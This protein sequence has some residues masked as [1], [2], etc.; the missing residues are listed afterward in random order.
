MNYA[1]EFLANEADQPPPSSG[2]PILAWGVIGLVVAVTVLAS[3]KEVP[4]G[5]EDRVGKTLLEI[6]ARYMIGAVEILGQGRDQFY[7]QAKVL[8]RG[9]VDHHLAFVVLAG[10]LAGP[11]EALRQLQI[12]ENNLVQYQVTGTKVQ[13][14]L[15]HILKRLYQDYARFHF[16]RLWLSKGDAAFLR[17][18]LGWFG[19]LAL[20]PA[21]I[22]LNDKIVNAVGGAGLAA[23]V[24]KARQDL[25]LEARKEVIAPAVQTVGAILGTICLLAMVALGGLVG[26]I[27]LLVQAHKGQVQSGLVVA[28]TLRVPSLATA[29]GV[30]SPATAH[31]VCLL[32][33]GGIY[34][35]TFALWLLVW[36]GLSWA[37]LTLGAGEPDLLLVGVAFLL[38]LAAL[39][40]PVLRGIPWSQVRQ[41]IGLTRGR[42]PDLEPLIGI[43]CYAMAL[44][45]LAMGLLLTV[46]LLSLG[47][48]QPEDTGNPFAPSSTPRHPLVD[49]LVHGDTQGIFLAVILACVVAP[50][51]EEIMFRG[52]L[53][54]H[55]REAS[56][57]WGGMISVLFSGLVTSFV[58][59]VIHPQGLAAVPALMALA[60][61]FTIAREWRGTLVPGMVAHA[62]NNGILVAVFL[63][64]MAN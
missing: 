11:H 62:L 34:A 2:W 64:T 23:V 32:R 16:D 9:P 30:S 63:L 42:N 19:E 59:A 13:Q 39:A 55:L 37:A 36:L 60:L 10:E 31:G 52:V 4:T 28:G 20:T 5:E 7:E 33:G 24:A 29:Y 46:V 44:P 25:D 12:L 1:P 18:H 51:V 57:R 58:F 17:H 14:K 3:G 53:Y 22:R 54:R 48:G 41:D 45:I 15:S 47:V 27:L 50:L 26:L 6:Q 38:S 40:W 49:Y 56:G 43:G 21:G 35:E 61:G 8:A